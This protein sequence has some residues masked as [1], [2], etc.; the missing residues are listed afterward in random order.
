MISARAKRK[1]RIKTRSIYVW[2][3]VAALHSVV[4]V[5]FTAKATPGGALIGQAPDQFLIIIA[6]ISLSLFFFF[7]SP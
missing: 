5:G 1:R 7:W 6:V 2:E 3:Q 4:R